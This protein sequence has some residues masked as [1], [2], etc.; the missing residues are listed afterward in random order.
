MSHFIAVCLNFAV[1]KM[2][3]IIVL[4]SEVMELKWEKAGSE[5]RTVPEI[6]VSQSSVS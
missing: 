6:Q 2:D 1:C 3:P 4:T 5:Q